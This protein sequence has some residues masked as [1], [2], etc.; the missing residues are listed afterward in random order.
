MFF[1]DHAMALNV[2]S[3]CAAVIVVGLLIAA[4]GIR[5][6][7][8]PIKIG[9]RQISKLKH[10]TSITEFG[11]LW[12]NFRN[13]CNFQNETKEKKKEKEKPSTRK[14]YNKISLSTKSAECYEF[15]RKQK[16]NEGEKVERAHACKLNFYQRRDKACPRALYAPEKDRRT[17]WI[18]G[19]GKRD[20]FF[21]KY[22]LARKHFYNN[23]E[24]TTP[25]DSDT[26]GLNNARKR[27]KERER[28]KVAIV[29]CFGWS[30]HFHLIRIIRRDEM[31]RTW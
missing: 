28:E 10:C 9:E 19:R 18:G 27:E 11:Q 26:R 15:R 22:E 31:A 3:R 12:G 8:R 7:S 2:D 16:V 25:F 1:P 20:L 24:N 23:T 14:I 30:V 13:G 17:H 5:G 29:F 4:P 21:R 6:I